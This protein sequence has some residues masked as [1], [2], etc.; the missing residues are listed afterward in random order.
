MKWATHAVVL[1][2]TGSDAHFA[3]DAFASALTSVGTTTLAVDPD[4][5]RVVASYE[6]A[7]DDA[8]RSHGPI[9]V[10]GISIGAAVAVSWAREHP[11]AV[12]GVLAALPPWLGEP[13]DA[14]AALSA[15]YT[16]ARLHELGLAEVTAGMTAS[17]PT[18]LSDTLTRSWA[19]QWPDLPS[20]LDEA[21]NYVAPT[22]DEL[23]RT[24]APTAIV[25]AVDDPVHP[26]DVGRTWHAELQKSAL[27]TV[28]LDEIGSDPGVLGRR[29]V[30][31]LASLLQNRADRPD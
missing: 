2:G 14:P 18:W 20:A 27:T 23:R 8:V 5:R 13:A 28:T 16:S 1:P 19:S 30:H 11:G 26:V 15:R 24:A 7:L 25:A 6:D 12:V 10:G 21:A 9:L 29:T 3:H 22:I 31:A 17:S 4:P